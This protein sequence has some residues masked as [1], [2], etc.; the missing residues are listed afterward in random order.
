MRAIRLSYAGREYTIPAERA[1]EI[2]ERVEDIATLSEIHS[3][4]K[5]PK[6]FKIARCYAEMLRFAG[7]SVS[8][9]EVHAE[10]MAQIKKAGAGGGEMMAAQAVFALIAVLMD[11]APEDDEASDE[12]KKT[13]AS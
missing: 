9:R 11:G 8:D 6:F 4:A 7:C 13:K 1:F 2:G 10:M 12:G 5:A 3:W